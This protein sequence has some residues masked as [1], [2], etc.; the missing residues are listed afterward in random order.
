MREKD[1][2]QAVA[3]EICSTF[4]WNGQ[5]FQ[6]GEVVA[7]LDGNVVAVAKDIDGA[8]RALRKIDPAPDRGMLFE[9][10]PPTIEWIRRSQYVHR[11]L[12]Q[13][14]TR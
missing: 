12:R 4:R 5:E 14:E 7:L 10:G 8:L 11:L 9:V 6:R 13:P 2:N 3:E 1:V